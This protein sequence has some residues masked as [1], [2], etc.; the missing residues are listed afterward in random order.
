MA[1]A[2]FVVRRLPLCRHPRIFASVRRAYSNFSSVPSASFK[3]SGAID[4]HTYCEFSVSGC[5]VTDPWGRNPPPKDALRALVNPANTQLVGT[6]LPYFPRGGPLPVLPPPELRV[7][8]GWG[9]MDAGSGM[10][11]RPPSPLITN[12]LFG[13][14][15][16]VA[17]TRRKSSMASRTCTRGSIFET[18][19]QQYKLTLTAIVAR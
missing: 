9:G 3:L 5:V 12:R 18:L 1:P 6:R 7:S 11:Y 14:K 17:G 13:I 15:H 16:D 4:S 8:S 2:L 10:L 19:F